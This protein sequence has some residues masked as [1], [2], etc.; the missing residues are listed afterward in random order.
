MSS[1]KVKNKVKDKVK[2]IDI[3]DELD[4]LAE[5]A[6]SLARPILNGLCFLIPYIINYSKKGYKMYH[7]LPHDHMELIIGLVLC[8]AGGFYPALFAAVEAARMGGYNNF[9]NACSTLSDEVLVI[10]EASKKD[11]AIDKDGDG[12]ADVNQ[13]DTDDY[14]MRKTEL[15]LTKMNPQKVSDAISAVYKVWLSVLAVLVVQFARV[16]TMSMTISEFVNKPINKYVVPVIKPAFPKE[17]HKWVPVTLNWIVKAIAMSIAW[18]IQT[19]ISALSSAM[20]GGLIVSRALMKLAVKKG[21]EF[22]P[23]NHE[24]TNLDEYIAYGMCAL[25][26]YFQFS[27]NFEVPFPFNI[28]L[29]PFELA[30]MFIKYQVANSK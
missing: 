25:G 20:R 1:E 11:D 27:M 7:K 23:K 17:Y 19:V 12:V 4:K 3:E 15:V 16:V 28:L 13:I 6:Q 2:D 8:L 30:E 18:Y 29:M 22:V 21:W 24:E 14:I 26:F 9:I 5:M 10:I